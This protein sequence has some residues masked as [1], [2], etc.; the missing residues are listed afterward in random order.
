MID[1]HTHLW[2]PAISPQYMADYFQKKKEAGKEIC[3]TAEELLA[4]MDRNGIQKAIDLTLAFHSMMTNLELKTLH[5]YTSEQVKKSKGRLV[6]FFTVNPF[7]DNVMEYVEKYTEKD[8]FV[9][10]KLHPNIQEFFPDDE[11]LRNI[12]KYLEEKRMPV[13]FHTGGIGLSGI[14]DCFGN[15]DAI[16][17]IACEFPE[18][19]IIMGHA[20]RIDYRRTAELLRKHPNVYADISTNFSRLHGK[21]W[22]MLKE[23]MEI[24]KIWCGNT[25]KLLFGSDYP[26]YSQ[27]QTT[28]IV[29]DFTKHNEL[30]TVLE[31]SDVDALMN[32]NA[33]LFCEKYK[34]WRMKE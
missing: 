33:E 30:F 25:E 8:K 28:E 14:R 7:E 20:G 22:L 26:F 17:H 9:G 31:R 23:L 4:H 18:L 11:R 21:E 34:L 12:Y 29:R 1:V 16:D 15:L 24:V 2:D 32:K 3:M 13:L 5:S 27:D 19:P 6:A 10:L